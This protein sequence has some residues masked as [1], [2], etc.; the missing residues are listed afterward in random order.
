[1]DEI[2]AKFLVEYQEI[3]EKEKNDQDNQN[4][5]NEENPISTTQNQVSL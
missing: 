1:M 5:E 3:E 2:Q 4:L